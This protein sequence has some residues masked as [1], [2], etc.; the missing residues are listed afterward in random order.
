MPGQGFG[1]ESRVAR[2]LIVA[3]VTAEPPKLLREMEPATRFRLLGDTDFVLIGDGV[4]QADHG[5][6]ERAAAELRAACDRVGG[7]WWVWVGHDQFLHR[8]EWAWF[9][10]RGPAGWVAPHIR[11][12]EA[13][14]EEMRRRE[15][16]QK[17]IDRAAAE[18]E[19]AK[20][21]LE[22]AGRRSKKKA[23]R[24]MDA[25]IEQVERGQK[26]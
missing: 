1:S 24:N 17:A 21:K 7:L 20:K 5:A 19:K 16:C 26:N 11:A 13:G 12:S 3:R 10:C 8:T 15:A 18:A 14:Y 6:M 23:P 4:R 25:I 9:Y 2:F 22:N